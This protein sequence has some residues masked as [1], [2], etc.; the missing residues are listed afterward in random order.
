MR[1]GFS[2][3]A[4]RAGAVLLLSG[5]ALASWGRPGV[6]SPLDTGTCQ[7]PR[8]AGLEDRAASGDSDAQYRLG[9]LHWE[10]GCD[11][12]ASA[13]GMAW[14]TRAAEAGHPAA[15]HYVGAMHIGGP[16]WMKAQHYLGIAARAG[17]MVAQHDLGILILVRAR[18]L[19][20]REQGLYWMGAAAGQGDG[21]SAAAIGMIHERG[22]HGVQRDE[23][24]ALDWYESAEAL[25]FWD[26]HDHHE[27]L[28]AQSVNRC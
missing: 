25:G 14:L 2:T 9:L 11:A 3:I 22:M 20:D 24:L 15:A 4:A 23:C 27:A 8:P 13:S 12:S 18:S 17:H 7:L 26:L 1:S 28:R 6:G 5:L 19:D 21:F 10:S 16:D